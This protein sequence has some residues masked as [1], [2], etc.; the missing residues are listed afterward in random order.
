MEHTSLETLQECPKCASSSRHLWN[1]LTDHS[2]S[3]EP[4]AVIDCTTCGFRF[5]NPRPD[6]RTVGSYYQSDNYYSHSSTSKT[7]V[8]RL[9]KLA[10]RWGVRNKHKI[11][12]SVQPKGRVL[13]VGCGTGEFLAYLMSRGYLV[14]GVEPN[15]TAREQAIANH[16]I[17]VVAN[18]DQIPG[19]EQFQV[20]TLWHVLEHVPDL[21]ATLKKIFTQLAS[22]GTLLIAVPDRGSWDA[23]HYGTFWAA[24]DVPR[25]FYH[26]RQTDIQALLREHG[27]LLVATKRMWMDAFYIAIL[28]EGYSGASRP[29][30]LIKGLMVG[31]WSNLASM[32][33]G[34]PT[35]SSLYVARKA[36]A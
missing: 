31:A 22:D 3:G 33:S 21:R 19:Y 14:D 2:I 35:S 27:F 9:Y 18:T 23:K 32:L 1:T 26:F 25:H 28:S 5:T 34:G 12:R 6:Q 30:A 16:G 17:Q 8:S 24:W 13:D 20:I 10:R 15:Q 11:I 7:I 4:F 36:K 29:V